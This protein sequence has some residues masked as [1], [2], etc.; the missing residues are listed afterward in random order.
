M[1]AINARDFAD[2]ISRRLA[3]G[4]QIG[5]GSQLWLDP[6]GESTLSIINGGIVDPQPYPI[7]PD[8]T[9]YRF[10]STAQEVAG[11]MSG[12]WWLERREL[13]QLISW[14][15]INQRS[16]GYA[17]RLLCCVPPEW[18]SAL[19]FLIAVRTVGSI[20]AWRG[21][22]NTAVAAY[23]PPA[24]MPKF[25]GGTTVIT[26]RNDTAALRVP[27]LFIPG[28]RSPGGPSAMFSFTGQWQTDGAADWVFGSGG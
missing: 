10:G 28:T 14:S 1:A 13:D 21:L 11:V 9:L 4:E 23:V 12:G 24:G 26:A 6:R 22:A 20:M 16:L 17:V 5:A 8:V 18:G 27:Q 15:R 19:N 7:G 25:A 2:P 3:R